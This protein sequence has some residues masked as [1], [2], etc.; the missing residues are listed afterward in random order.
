MTLKKEVKI[1]LKLLDVPNALVNFKSNVYQPFLITYNNGKKVNEN[2]KYRIGSNTKMFIGI[3]LLMLYEEG[4]VNLDDPVSKYLIGIPNDITIREIGEMRSGLF[5]Y[6]ASDIFQKTLNENPY[7]NWLSDELL[8][9]GVTNSVSF[10]PGT[11]VA[12]SNT[13]TIILA[14]II[15]RITGNSIQHELYNRII[16]PLNLYNTKFMTDGVFHDPIMHG[17][18]LDNNHLKDVTYYNPSWAWAAGAMTSNIS[19]MS[20][21]IKYGIGKH[22]LLNDNATKQQRSWASCQKSI[23]FN[24]LFCYGFQ[25]EKY[26]TYFGHNGAL[27]G[28]NSISLYDVKTDTTII[29]AINLQVKKNDISPAQFIGEYIIA[30]L[31]NKTTLTEAKKLIK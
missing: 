6:T 1:L 12:Y 29:V 3:L 7:R 31:N 26:D 11:N 23:Y 27:P 24:L 10:E 21:F 20:V 13:N 15:E 28:Y 16:N 2:D 9:I 4:L 25:L 22:V 19:D 17:Y 8:A 18:E 5:N 30:R 14:L